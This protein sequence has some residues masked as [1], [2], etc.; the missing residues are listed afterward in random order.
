MFDLKPEEREILWQKLTTVFE[1]YYQNTE[2]IPV[3]P[4]LNKEE[5]QQFII[6]RE[7]HTPIDALNHVT[8]GLTKYAVHT[9]H[10]MYYGLYNPRS[11]FAGIV[12]DTMTAIFNPQMAAWSHSPFAVEVEDFIIRE[13][14]IRFGYNSEEIDGAFCSGGAEANLTALVCASQSKFPE[15]KTQ[16]WKNINDRPLIYCSAEAHHSVVKAAI[17]IGLGA[18]AVRML[19]INQKL[20]I[21]VQYL[22]QVLEEDSKNGFRPMLVIA[23]E[24]V[25]GTGVIDD[26]SEIYPLREQY[27]FWLHADAAYGGALA[28]SDT[29]KHL[30]AD[31]AQADSITFDAHKWLS[32]PMGAGIYITRHKNIM[33]DSFGIKT[34]YMPKDAQGMDVIDPFTHT[35]QWSRRFTGLKLYMSL[36]MYGWEGMEQMVDQQIETGDYLKQ[37]LSQHGWKIYNDTRL[38]VVCFGLEKFEKDPDSIISF[39]QKVIGTGKVWISVYKIGD[40]HTLRACVTNYNT[41]TRHIDDLVEL[42]SATSK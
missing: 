22:A 17:I 25:T 12:G 31:I 30:L 20:T 34:E 37:S 2:S 35:I 6:N 4:K 11:S 26:I 38:P 33:K 28:L 23:T 29:Y 36:L 32:V 3:T 9:P 8:D 19:P 14:G 16:G 40:I 24:G 18:D 15:I 1:Q 21:D 27:N 13:L 7:I 41:C 39:C 42:L 10:P 5:I